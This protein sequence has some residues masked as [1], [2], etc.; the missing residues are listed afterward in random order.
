MKLFRVR[1]EDLMVNLLAE[2]K[3]MYEFSGIPYDEDFVK[4]H[5][6]N[7]TSSGKE[8]KAFNVFRSSDFDFNHWRKELPESKIREIEKSCQH[9]MN[10][11]QYSTF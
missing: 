9:F 2:T 3:S 10:E 11:L 7:L 6:H 8:S 4:E 1:Y 5:I